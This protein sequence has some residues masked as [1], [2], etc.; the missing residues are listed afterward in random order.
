MFELK[1][2]SLYIYFFYF[3]LENTLSLFCIQKTFREGIEH[4]LKIIV[5]C[6][7]NFPMYPLGKE[8]TLSNYI[9]K[10]KHC[11]IYS[12][13][14]LTHSCIQVFIYCLYFIDKQRLTE[15]S[16]SS[17][18]PLVSADILVTKFIFRKRRHAV[19]MT[20]RL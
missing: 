10:H 8:D 5:W 4:W 7:A 19:N 20:S 6:S 2:L 12:Q 18:P 16:D 3:Q 17:E 15:F 11:E 9:R 14:P 1:N 13:G